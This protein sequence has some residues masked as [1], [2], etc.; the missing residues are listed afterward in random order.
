MVKGGGAAA[1]STQELFRGSVP[2]RLEGR[3]RD[4]S[5]DDKI[6]NAFRVF[7]G[8]ER[9]TSSSEAKWPVLLDK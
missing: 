7:G 5:R 6:N 1:I 9:R 3:A 4:I 2:P 8:A